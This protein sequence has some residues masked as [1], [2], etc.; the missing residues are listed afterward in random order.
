VDLI[1]EREAAR[2]L[3]SLG[4]S[5]SSSQHLLS[6]GIAGTAFRAGGMKLYDATRVCEVASRVPVSAQETRRLFPGG[7]LVARVSRGRVVDAAAEWPQTAEELAGPW[8][9]LSGGPGILLWLENLSGRSVP[10]MLSVAGCVVSGA[11]ITGVLRPSETR[12]PGTTFALAAPGQW[13][14]EV[15]GRML[16]FGRGA[17]VEVLGDLARTRRDRYGKNAER[18]RR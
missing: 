13:L 17:A 8:P 10:L 7:A 18:A 16:T 15:R 2:V 6:T 11:T 3:A 14:E 12:G 1:S 9:Q 4:L 5:R